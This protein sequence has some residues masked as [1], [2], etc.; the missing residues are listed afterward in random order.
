MNAS[1]QR[2]VIYTEITSLLAGRTGYLIGSSLK[3]IA[4]PDLS[5]FFLFSTKT[6]N[7][8]FS[9]P[10]ND[11]SEASDDGEKDEVHGARER[12][13]WGRDSGYP[14]SEADGFPLIRF[15]VSGPLF[16]DLEYG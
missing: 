6:I 4:D 12:G 2:H 7:Q 10:L 16:T 1:D 8:Y 14:T 3:A 13:R 9:Q 11:D 5:Y 15:R